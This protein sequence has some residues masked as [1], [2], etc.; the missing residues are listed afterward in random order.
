MYGLFSLAMRFIWGTLADRFSVRVAIILQA[1]MTGIAAILLLQVAGTFS[2][3]LIMAFQGM[4]LS[5]YPPV[6]ILVWPEFFGRMHIG[7]IVGLTQFVS[8]IAG[9]GGPLL[10]GVLFD[11]TGSHN[12]SLWLLVGTWAAC[13][14]VMMI[15]KPAQ[16]GEAEAAVLKPV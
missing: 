8:T 3:Y 11:Q 16:K 5:G 6:Q 12:T 9:A 2:L 7:S 10:V 1:F 13:M 15:V 14:S 4:T